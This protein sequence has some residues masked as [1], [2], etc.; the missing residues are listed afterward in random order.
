MA[1]FPVRN[2]FAGLLVVLSVFAAAFA[3]CGDTNVG[4][5][6]SVA[7]LAGAAGGPGF[8]D[9]SPSDPVRFDSP[10]RETT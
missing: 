6:E 1:P 10:S 8:F 7:A 3:G 9:G 2:C 5:A 4:K